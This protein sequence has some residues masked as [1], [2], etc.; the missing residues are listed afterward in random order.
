MLSGTTCTCT[1]PRILRDQYDTDANLRA[2]IETHQRYGV[3]PG[4]EPAVREALAMKGDESLLDLGTGPGDWPGS[5]RRDGHR[6]RLVGIDL[7]AGMIATARSKYPQV[8]FL[9]ADAQSLPFDNSSFDVV[10]ARHMLYHVPDIPRALRETRRVLKSGGHFLAVTNAAGYMSE[11][12]DLLVE[13]ANALGGAEAD[14]MRSVVSTWASGGFSNVNGP[15]LIRS[16]FGNVKVSTI[17][18]ALRFESPEP[19]VRYFNSTRTLRGIDE[20]QWARIAEQVRI[21]VSRHLTSGPWTVSKRVVL[22]SA[23][24][25]P[26]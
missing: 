14:A 15:E 9:R 11:Y 22:M 25:G 10:T 20:S 4:L 1:D 7:S 2:R 16:A 19:V 8:E 18:S 17:D 21:A 26:S 5:L 24:R 3:G 13:A 6:G 12:L 23:A